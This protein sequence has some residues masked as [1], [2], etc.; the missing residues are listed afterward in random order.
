MV[1]DVALMFGFFINPEVGLLAR[2]TAPA[3]PFPGTL[4]R[5]LRYFF[6]TDDASIG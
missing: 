3:E 2:W 6:D 1:F 5:L 4:S